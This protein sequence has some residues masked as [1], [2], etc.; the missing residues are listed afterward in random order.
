VHTLE[1]G[2]SLQARTLGEELSFE[3]AE[4]AVRVIAPAAPARAAEVA[5]SWL[6]QRGHMP[7]VQSTLPALLTAL[8]RPEHADAFRNLLEDLEPRLAA[9]CASRGST[10]ESGGERAHRSALNRA[11]RGLAAI[12][13]VEAAAK[14]EGHRRVGVV[15]EGATYDRLAAACLALGDFAQADEMLE[16]RDYL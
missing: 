12:D 15:I 9:G 16:M 1:E 13:V 5:Q 10:A 2:R 14:T 3:A 11:L 4:A 7:C 6:L 8:A